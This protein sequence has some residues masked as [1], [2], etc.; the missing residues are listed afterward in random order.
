MEQTD[1]ALVARARTGDKSAF[2]QLYAIPPEQNESSIQHLI[3]LLVE[4][5][6]DLA[7]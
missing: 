5:S 7:G 3:T 4:D 1:S 2:G 6:G